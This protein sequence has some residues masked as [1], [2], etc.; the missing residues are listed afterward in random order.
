MDFCISGSV[1]CVC[2]HVVSVE[3]VFSISP[4]YW[5]HWFLETSRAKWYNPLH[6]HKVQKSLVMGSRSWSSMVASVWPRTLVMWHI[7]S[8]IVIVFFCT[9]PFPSLL[10]S[11]T[12]S[13]SDVISH[14]IWSFVV[15]A[16]PGR[17]GTLRDSAGSFQLWRDA[18]F[19][20]LNEIAC[21][22]YHQWT[23]KINKEW[24]NHRN[25]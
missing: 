4:C 12:M 25:L 24:M 2:V 3:S 1:V 11:T 9:K 19:C 7:T 14:G 16:S 23:S 8:E 22:K 18:P 10:T 6:P 13:R 15:A 21:I 20:N 17:C 5:F